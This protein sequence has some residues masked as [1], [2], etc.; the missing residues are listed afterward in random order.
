LL[1]KILS[2][3]QQWVNAGSDY[4]KWLSKIEN[5][6]VDYPPKEVTYPITGRD[7]SYVCM[8]LAQ[9][10]EEGHPVFAK[11]AKTHDQAVWDAIEY[12]LHK[13]DLYYQGWPILLQIASADLERERLYE[14][15][16]IKDAKALA[17]KQEEHAKVLGLD[18]ETARMLAALVLNNEFNL[19]AIM[20]GGIPQKHPAWE[21]F[22]ELLP[23]GLAE[24]WCAEGIIMT[25]VQAAEEM[26]C[27][28]VVPA[29]EEMQSERKPFWLISQRAASLFREFVVP[30]MKAA[31]DS[32]LN[33]AI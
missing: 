33:Q 27:A 23:S 10:K 2:S 22:I 1:E 29:L 32:R 24:E 31:E 19:T 16:L 4:D 20:E 18:L 3:Q 11:A 9:A 26:D 14:Q 13:F 15:A 25:V 21:S 7:Y 30:A 6:I 28:E 5:E 17:F 12:A 8:S